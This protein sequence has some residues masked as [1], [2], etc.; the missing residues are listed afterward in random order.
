MEAV[1]YLN[2]RLHDVSSVFT[3]RV[4]ITPLHIAKF[5]KTVMDCLRKAACW[6]SLCEADIRISSQQISRHVGS[7]KVHLCVHKRRLLDFVPSLTTRVQFTVSL[8]ILF[9][10]CTECQFVFLRS[11]TIVSHRNPASDD[12]SCEGALAQGRYIGSSA[13]PYAPGS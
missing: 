9:V 13:L 8:A 12:T 6:K 5:S 2:R 4:V 11:T 1:C 3:Y 10:R 7:K